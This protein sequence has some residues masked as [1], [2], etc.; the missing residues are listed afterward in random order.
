[1]RS[2]IG[3][4][5][6]RTALRQDARTGDDGFQF[7]RRD[8]RTKDTLDFGDLLFSL[9]NSLADRSPED[10]AKL[11]LVGHRQEFG[12]DPRDQCE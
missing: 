1:M 5:Q 12:P 8:H 4:K 2:G 11:T 7:I 10:D 6:R 3:I 9:F